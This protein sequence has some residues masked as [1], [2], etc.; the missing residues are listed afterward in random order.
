MTTSDIGPIVHEAA[1]KA[2]E[3]SAKSDLA[4]NL[5]EDQLR[6]FHTALT[7]AEET[8]KTL[9]ELRRSDFPM[10]AIAAD[11]AG[12]KHRLADGIGL[13]WFRGLPVTRYSVEQWEKLY[14]GLGLHLGL[15]VSQSNLG[16]LVGH[17]VN[18]GGKDRR[19]RAYR[20]NRK[21]DLHT[22][23]CDYI[24]MLCLQKAKSGG[25]SGYASAL[26][27]HN[28]IHRSRPELLAPLYKGFKLHRFGEQP[29]GK[30]PITEQNIPIFS[31]ADG[32]P[33]VIY[34]RGYIDLAIQEGFYLPSEVEQAALDYFDELASSEE[35]CFNM[36]LEPGEAVF[37]NNC[38]LLHKR[39]AF[40]DYEEPERRRHL[41]RLWLSDPERPASAGV[42]AHKTNRGIEKRDDRGTYYQ[43]PGYANPNV[44]D[45]Y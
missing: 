19:E 30:P 25:V 41:L 18:I 34:I 22:D 42:R 6:A 39:T 29:P 37:T 28:E 26:A 44:D 2:G 43:G 11:I 20:N 4:V 33:N 8:G 9:T 16:D 23:R 40:E 31:L 3:L 5:T 45:G 14:L 17:V 27:V 38:L 24:G 36:L 35:F 1:W 15:P 10:P 32:Y 12:W 7:A 21:L 13:V